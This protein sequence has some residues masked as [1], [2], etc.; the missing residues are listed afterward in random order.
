MYALDGPVKCL[1]VVF[2]GARMRG[3]RAINL[4]DHAVEGVEVGLY[5]KLE[6]RQLILRQHSTSAKVIEYVAEVCGVTV[7]EHL[8]IAR[9]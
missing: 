7:Y 9:V 2:D 3:Q 1:H 5:A 6:Q 4:F 8:R